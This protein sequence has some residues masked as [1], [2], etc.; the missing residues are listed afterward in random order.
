MKIGR[1]TIGHEFLS[2]E[3][4][5]FMVNNRKITRDGIVTTG[6]KAN[7]QYFDRHFAYQH[8]GQSNLDDLPCQGI[9][10]FRHNTFRRR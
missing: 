5:Y 2:L 1:N 8:G 9:Q 10:K 6:F 7:F 4:S 3:N